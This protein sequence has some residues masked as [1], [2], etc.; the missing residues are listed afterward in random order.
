MGLGAMRR[1]P[2]GR[3]R[4][5]T[6]MSRLADEDGDKSHDGG[7]RIADTGVHGGDGDRRR[8][9]PGRNGEGFQP[10]PAPSS[11]ADRPG[12]DALVPGNGIGTPAGS[13]GHPS[14]NQALASS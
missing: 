4:Q 9:S 12:A 2:G 13:G 5:P 11:E 14:A 6:S 7:A 8:R 10:G 3:G 1:N